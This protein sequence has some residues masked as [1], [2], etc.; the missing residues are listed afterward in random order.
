MLPELPGVEVKLEPEP[1]VGDQPAGAVQLYELAFVAEAVKVIGV[2]AQPE[3]LPFTVAVPGNADTVTFLLPGVPLPQLFDGV[4]VTLPELPGVEVKLEPEPVLGDHPAGVV[5]LNELAFV[6]DAVKVI[7][8]PAH[9]E[10]LPETV[11]APGAVQV[12]VIGRY[13]KLLHSSDSLTVPKQL[14][15]FEPALQFP[16]SAQKNK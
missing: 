2:P 1:D 15:Q 16:P 13:T 5:Q 11:A 8:V 4:A 7:E 10:L 9:P 14:L 12:T 3:L 6:A